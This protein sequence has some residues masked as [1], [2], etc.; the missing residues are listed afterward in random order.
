[1]YTKH[2][3]AHQYASVFSKLSK[4]SIKALYQEQMFDIINLE[5]LIVG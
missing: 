1:M 4:F 2:I 5:H 3:L